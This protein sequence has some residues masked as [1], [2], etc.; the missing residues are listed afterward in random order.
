ML[1][2]DHTHPQRT[3]NVMVGNIRV[4]RSKTSMSKKSLRV[5][6]A[7]QWNLLP[8]EL[9]GFVGDITK[10]KKELKIWVKNNVEM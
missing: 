10:F 5:R 7:E 8:P 3:R 4:P 2:S 1:N 6:G 9:K